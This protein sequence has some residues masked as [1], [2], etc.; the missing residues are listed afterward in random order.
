MQLEATPSAAHSGNAGLILLLPDPFKQS[1]DE[2]QD[3]YS[4]VCLELPSSVGAMGINGL[5]TVSIST[6]T[7][8]V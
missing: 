1:R 2:N 3:S 4:Q 7:D 6:L 5:W 8:T